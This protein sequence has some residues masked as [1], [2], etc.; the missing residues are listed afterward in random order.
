MGGGG[1]AVVTGQFR[2]RESQAGRLWRGGIGAVVRM[3]LYINDQ[4]AL[5]TVNYRYF[6]PNVR[7][8]PPAHRIITLFY[9]F[10]GAYGA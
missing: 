2:I 8:F 6:L 7:S 10:S 9:P 3:R 4:S 1:D 5:L